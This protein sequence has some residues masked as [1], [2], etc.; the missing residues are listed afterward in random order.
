MKF[1]MKQKISTNFVDFWPNFHKK[2]NYFYH[3]LS[4]DYEVTIDELHPDIVF[5]S[6]FGA[7]AL[8]QIDRYKDHH[9]LKI[10]YTGENDGPKNHPYDASITQHRINEDNHFRLPLWAFFT[11]W[12][13]ESPFVNSRDPS[14]LIPWNSLDKN[15]LDLEAI[16]DTKTRFCSFVYA[17]L[18]SERERW[19]HEIGLISKVDSAGSCLNNMGNRIPGRGDQVYKLAFL[20]DYFF[21]LAIENSCVYGYATE[22]LIH[23]MSMC[24]IPM[25]WGDPGIEEDVNH[26]SI[27]DLRETP[28]RVIDEVKYLTSSKQRYLDKLEKPW[29]KHNYAKK[30]SRDILNFIIEL[31]Y[32]KRLNVK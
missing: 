6:C 25:Y 32:K 11:S 1:I 4:Q 2:D 30:Y 15:K 21:S 24:V 22:K 14:F 8:R 5:G 17:D 19:Y 9:T 7:G 3:L 18:T 23:P 29:F 13:G 31:L 10:Y 26:E 27:I 12:F 28:S 16:V 20:S